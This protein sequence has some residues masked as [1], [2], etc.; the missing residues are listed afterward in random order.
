M[1]SRLFRIHVD[2]RVQQDY[3]L[4]VCTGKYS[5]AEAYRVGNLAYREAASADRRNVLVD[6]RRVSGR[7]PTLFDRFDFGVHIAQLHFEQWPRVRLAVLGD[8]PMIHAERFGEI[9]ARNR[10]ADA[11]VFVEE[12]EALKWLLAA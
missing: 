9:V 7:L 12:Q 8:E 3:V 5:R 6:V 4:V 1:I 11:R 2:V 10:G